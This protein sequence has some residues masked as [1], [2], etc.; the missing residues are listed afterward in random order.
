MQSQAVVAPT[1]E[2]ARIPEAE[3]QALAA[4]KLRDEDGVPLES[5]WHRFQINLLDE[6]IKSHWSD[7][8]DFFVGGNMFLYFS[9]NQEKTADYKGPDLFVVRE[10]EDQRWRTYWAIW[11]EGNKTPDLVVELLS[12]STRREDL[13]RKKRL[14]ERRLHIPEYVCWGADPVDRDAPAELY[15][16]RLTGLT[17]QPIAPNE[18]GWVWSEVLEAWLGMWEG[19]YARV[20][21]RWLRLYDREG[22][23]V[24]T[25]AERAERE[26]DAERQRAEDAERQRDAERRRAEQAEHERDVERQRLE[27]LKARLR[28]RGIDLDL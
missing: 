2:P 3:L 23:L 12:E 22:N 15:A 10:V 4:L 20:Q 24:P 26:R 16:W 11:E 21:A 28:A 9:P 8:N 19:E 27:Q 18:R 6:C 25:R 5:P 1:D 14:Y 13:G 17:Y 7:R